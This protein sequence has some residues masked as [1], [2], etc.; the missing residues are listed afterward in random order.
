MTSFS[1]LKKKKPKPRK[2]TEKKKKQKKANISK[3]KKLGRGFGFFSR[4]KQKPASQ[5]S[6]HY[7]NDGEAY[8]KVRIYMHEQKK[9]AIE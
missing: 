9:K 4:S 5:F 2:K 7:I 3:F 6:S 1:T 8:D